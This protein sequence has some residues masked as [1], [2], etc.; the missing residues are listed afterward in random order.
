VPYAR[1]DA[2]AVPE[3]RWSA[4]GEFEGP[5]SVANSVMH[6]YIRTTGTDAGIEI[7]L[8]VHGDVAISID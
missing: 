4:G 6:V 5:T 1:A 3:L 2:T 8:G 7:A